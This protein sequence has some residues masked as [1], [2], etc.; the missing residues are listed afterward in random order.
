MRS[1]DPATDQKS[2][3]E[4]TLTSPDGN[5]EPRPVVVRREP[6]RDLVVWTAPGRP[7]KRRDR[8]F[9]V[10]TFAIAGIV[11]L[12]LF[13]A[14]GIM[15]VILIISLVFLYYVLSTVQPDN[16]E[17]KITTK[18]VK[19]ASKLTE[20]QYLNRYWF[21]KRFD[22]ELMIMDTVMLPGRIEFVINPEI[23]E[24]LKKEISAYIPYEEV[25]PATLDK[26]TGWF[27]AKLPGN[28]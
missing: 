8:Q 14:E 15:P 19:I 2:V 26:I 7:F 3:D 17:Y 22:N 12:I 18:G 6:E 5:Q 27:A 10:T 24:K 9:Y 16:I 4:S 21:T 23:K 1:M 13:L 20:W 25:P 28:K 11:S